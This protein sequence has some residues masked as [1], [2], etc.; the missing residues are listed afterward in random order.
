MEKPA[1]GPID[2]QRLREIAMRSLD[3]MDM[4]D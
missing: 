1:E 2:A 3:Q 4:K